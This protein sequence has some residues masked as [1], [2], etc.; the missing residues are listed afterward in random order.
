MEACSHNGSFCTQWTLIFLF[1]GFDFS[2]GNPT[3]GN[4]VL[5]MTL[6]PSH[7]DEGLLLDAL[8]VSFPYLHFDVE[9]KKA[10]AVITEAQPPSFQATLAHP[11][12]KLL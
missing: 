8:V 6:S 9:V 11:K 12:L 2:D 10:E 7:V 4:C 3:L 1:H 5:L